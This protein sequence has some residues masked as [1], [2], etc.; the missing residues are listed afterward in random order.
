MPF[1][2]VEALPVS[3][4]IT[5][6]C[7]AEVSRRY[8]IP[9][10][11]LGGVLAQERGRLGQSSP[12]KNGSWDLGPMQV[13]SAWLKFFAPYAITEHRLKHDGCA[14]LAVGAWIIRYE[15]GRAKGGLW[16]AVG[17]YH[18]HRPELA[19]AYQAQVA[20]KLGELDAGRLTLAQLLEEANGGG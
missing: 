7:V 14:N 8:Q 17:R 11:L 9:V 1:L 2:A 20:A 19:A 3:Q 15:Q 5:I 18:S 10:A 12:N 16:Q 6:E 4:P 13:N